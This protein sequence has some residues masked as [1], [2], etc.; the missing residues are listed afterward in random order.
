MIDPGDPLGH[1]HVVGVLGLEL[2]LQETSLRAPEIARFHRQATVGGMRKSFFPRPQSA[3][4]SLDCS[5]A[6]RRCTIT[7]RIKSLSRNG[8]RNE[9]CVC[10]SA[11]IP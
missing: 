11:S 5:P 2:E 10:S 9:S 1:S 7:R 8:V 4:Q 6:Q 3:A